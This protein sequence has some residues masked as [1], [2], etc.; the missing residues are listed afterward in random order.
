M[1]AEWMEVRMKEKKDILDYL[2]QIIKFGMVT[3]WIDLHLQNVTPLQIN[4]T[5]QHFFFLKIEIKRKTISSAG[6]YAEQLELSYT[7]VNVKWYKTLGKN[8]DSFL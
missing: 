4:W 1:F 7:L 5:H 8:L 6:D 3:I 2:T